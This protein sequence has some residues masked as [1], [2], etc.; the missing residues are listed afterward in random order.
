M[1]LF[2]LNKF[3]KFPKALFLN[4]RTYSEK[5]IKVSTT[6]LIAVPNGEFKFAKDLNREDI[7][8]TYDFEKQSQIDEKIKS[9]LIEPVEGY[10]APL[11]M[12]GT[13]IVDGVLTSCYAIIDSQ[14]IAHTVMAPIRWWYSMHGLI[15]QAAPESLL[16]T[17]QIEKQMNGTHWYPQMLQSFTSDY[18][19]KFIKLH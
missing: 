13:M 11:T 3:L 1:S 5:S 9:I 7:I 12:S 19:N 16:N 18:L 17:I 2:F 15:D 14:F 4:I 8:I 10:A 6:H